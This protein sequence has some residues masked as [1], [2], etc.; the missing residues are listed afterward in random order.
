MVESMFIFKDDS[1]EKKDITLRGVNKELYEHFNEFRLKIGS[2]AGE[3][4]SALLFTNLRQPW[5]M[6]GLR[7]FGGHRRMGIIP[8]KICDL[9]KLHVSKRDLT[10]AGEKTMFLFRNIQELVFEKDVDVPTLVKHVKLISH[11]NVEFLGEIPK[12]IQSGLIRKKPQYIHPTDKDQLKDIT[13][14]NVSTKLYDE[15][16]AKAKSESITT[17][18]LFSKFIADILPFNLIHEALENIGDREALIVAHEE[19]LQI[20]QE[21]LEVLGNRGVIFYGINSLS[22][23]SDIDQELF[24]NTV[25]KIIRC[26]DVKLPKNVPRL[27]ALSRIINSTNVTKS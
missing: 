6:H 11:A 21:D 5:S 12:L 16:I 17:G 14:R 22:F 15:F 26:T 25:F 10:S 20:T 7:R 3:A 13:I 24:L 1:D 19:K 27:I 18:E 9:E 23:S 2:S 8:E 4:F